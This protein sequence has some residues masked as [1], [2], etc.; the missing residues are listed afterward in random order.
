MTLLLIGGIVVG[1][2]IGA[3]FCYLFE[4]YVAPHLAKFLDGFAREE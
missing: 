2:I 1:C 4:K 3:G